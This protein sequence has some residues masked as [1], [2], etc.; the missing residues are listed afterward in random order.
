MRFILFITVFVLF[1]YDSVFSQNENLLSF[2]AV[3]R[4][5]TD[6]EQLMVDKFVN[7][8][9]FSQNY[10]IT[11]SDLLES[12]EGDN[13]SVQFPWNSSEIYSFT[14]LYSNSI[15]LSGYRWR[16][17]DDLGRSFRYTKVNG[18]VR[19]EY[20]DRFNN[21][22]FLF[23][24][25][26]DGLG[27]ISERELDFL[28]VNR[29]GNTDLDLDI[30]AEIDAEVRSSCSSNSKIRILYLYT[31]KV[32]EQGETPEL[33]GEEITSQLNEANSRSNISLSYETA[34]FAL[35]EDFVEDGQMRDDVDNNLPNNESKQLRDEFFADFVCL[36]GFYNQQGQPSGIVKKIGASNKNAYCIVHAPEADIDP[37]FSGAHE[38]GHLLGAKHQ[39]CSLCGD[40][41]CSNG[42]TNATGHILQTNNNI[43][44]LMT[45]L[46]CTD[47]R[48]DVVWSNK[49]LTYVS[50]ND[51]QVDQGSAN[52]DVASKHIRRFKKAACFRDHPPASFSNDNGILEV[53]FTGPTTLVEDIE[54][55]WLSSVTDG[56]PMYSY[57]W[58]IQSLPLG[59]FE[60]ISTDQNLVSNLGGIPGSSFV[61]RLEVMDSNGDWGAISKNLFTPWGPNGPNGEGGVYRLSEENTES[62]KYHLDSLEKQISI[63]P[64]PTM[65]RIS[66]HSEIPFID[67]RIVNIN[68][69]YIENIT[70]EKVNDNSLGI[71]LSKLNDG[72]YFIELRGQDFRIVRKIIKL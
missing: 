36:I 42:T 56:V 2:H 14:R 19:G 7:K 45:V 53:D 44:T 6:T 32:I 9:D 60:L 1:S 52:A 72:I 33:I 37:F 46:D 28:E 47:D 10:V 25:N 27:V 20:I 8:G 63:S 17:V 4:E 54:Y 30:D 64:N 57:Q 65:N 41:G 21:K 61:L 50:A 29:C 67:A 51:E 66:V 24:I 16:G 31:D 12:L 68:G 39:K 26:K 71:D 49:D 70:F 58:S 62:D 3:N 15:G 48:V 34:G 35:L 11:L 13:L 38:I 5:L 23:E 69:V 43:S 22:F 55:T 18:L 59:P 40:D